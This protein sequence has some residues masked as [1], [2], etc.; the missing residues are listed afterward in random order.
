[1]RQTRVES[2]TDYV[3]SQG[4]TASLSLGLSDAFWQL[5]LS[6]GT[7]ERASTSARSNIE[8][9]RRELAISHLAHLDAKTKYQKA[10][11]DLNLWEQKIRADE[12][13]VRKEREALAADREEVR[14]EREALAADLGRT[15][16][17]IQSVV[18]RHA[19]MSKGFRPPLPRIKPQC[20]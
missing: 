17:T 12:E 1:M 5:E 7:A 18:E 14:K 2:S 9:L 16:Q 11:L 4:S 8:R 6:L 15:A 19:F 20:R 13:E 10:E 3:T